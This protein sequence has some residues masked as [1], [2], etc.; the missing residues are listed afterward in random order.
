MVAEHQF[1][2]GVGCLH[3]ISRASHDAAFVRLG[4]CPEGLRGLL[5]EFE[6]KRLIK[7]LLRR[8]G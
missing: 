8:V 6:R 4:S 2:S 3:V 1:V 7:A 5:F